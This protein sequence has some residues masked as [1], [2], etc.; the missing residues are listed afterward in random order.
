MTNLF[1]TVDAGITVSNLYRELDNL[2]EREIRT[3]RELLTASFTFDSICEEFAMLFEEIGTGTPEMAGVHD[4]ACRRCNSIEERLLAIENTAEMRAQARERLLRIEPRQTEETGEVLL[5]VELDPSHAQ[6]GDLYQMLMR[7]NTVAG[8][9]R[10]RAVVRV[11]ARLRIALE[12]K[13][14]GVLELIT[15][16]FPQETLEA[17]LVLWDPYQEGSEFDSFANA[18]VAAARL[19]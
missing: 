15:G 8:T 6:I 17:A 13:H 12:S 18:L 16:E 19:G 14:L 1:D 10:Q 3:V 11:P 9:L 4:E 5:A 7:Q 2:G